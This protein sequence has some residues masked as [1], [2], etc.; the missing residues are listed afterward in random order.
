[1]TNSQ[2]PETQNEASAMAGRLPFDSINPDSDD[3]ESFFELL[4]EYFIPFDIKSDTET[5][6]NKERGSGNIHWGVMLIDC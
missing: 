1:M 6:A 3:I 5:A 2:A 4:H